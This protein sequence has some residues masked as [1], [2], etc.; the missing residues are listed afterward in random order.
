MEEPQKSRFKI[1]LWDQFIRPFYLL[2]NLFQLQALLLACFILNLLIWKNVTL[3][4]IVILL[5][6]TIFI[7]QNIKYYQS[8]EFIHNYRKFKSERGEYKDYRKLTKIL[9][10]EKKE[11]KPKVVIL[12]NNPLSIASYTE[13]F[14]DNWKAITE[15]KE[16]KDD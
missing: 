13:E 14:P 6:G 1:F 5:L 4:W 8:G 16:N 9:K 15:A 10:K 7:Y 2:L 11:E 3:F 12:D